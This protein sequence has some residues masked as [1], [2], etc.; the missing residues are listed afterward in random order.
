VILDNSTT[1][2]TGSQNHPGTGITI[3]GQKTT[4]PDLE[5]LVK[6]LGITWVKSINPYDVKG[7]RQTV[8]E[9]LEYD[10]PS[11]IISKAPCVLLNT[12]MVSGKA[13]RVDE[14]KCT[15]CKVCISLGC[16]AIEFRDEKAHI[17]GVCVGCNVCAEICP[18]DA[19]GGDA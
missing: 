19:I 8:N 10:G 15:G 12:R 13:L 2:M 18:A 9:A 4:D 1:A 11:V 7:A 16:P 6:A 3:E 14:E 17:N 5:A